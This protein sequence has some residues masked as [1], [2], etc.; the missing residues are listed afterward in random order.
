MV[1]QKYISKKR[2]NAI[3]QPKRSQTQ[4][5]DRG[6]EDTAN[7]KLKSDLFVYHF[8]KIRNE[9]STIF[10]VNCK[11]YPKSYKWFASSDYEIYQKYLE[12]AHLCE[13]VSQRCKLKY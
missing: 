1:N 9:M 7:Q 3:F 5:G 2:C 6:E 12:R 8:M 10:N 11:Y 13:A 4:G